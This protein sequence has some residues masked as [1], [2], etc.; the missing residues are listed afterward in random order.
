MRK[1]TIRELRHQEFVP[2]PDSQKPTRAL[3]NKKPAVKMNYVSSRTSRNQT[4]KALDDETHQLESLLT[5]LQP[6]SVE[7]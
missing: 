5:V 7:L 1:Q 6:V 4:R 3:E 2:Q